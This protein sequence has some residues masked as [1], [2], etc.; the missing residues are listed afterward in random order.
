MPCFKLNF[1]CSSPNVHCLI[2]CNENV[3]EKH[4]CMHNHSRWQRYCTQP[5]PK[6]S[7]AIPYQSN[8]IWNV[9]YRQ[10]RQNRDWENQ[11]SFQVLHGECS[12]AAINVEMIFESHAVSKMT[13]MMCVISKMRANTRQAHER[14][15]HSHSLSIKQLH[16]PSSAHKAFHTLYTFHH[17]I[18]N[19][20]YSILEWQDKTA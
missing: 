8:K 12:V 7:K 11:G 15:S 20:V 13:Q 10:E 9:L 2:N 5:E 6:Q 19:Y 18:H 3:L 14:Q 1:M 4:E 16:I 17:K